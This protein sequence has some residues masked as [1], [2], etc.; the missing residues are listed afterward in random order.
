VGRTLIPTWHWA[1]FPPSE[2]GICSYKCLPIMTV[3]P[4]LNLGT[5]AQLPLQDKEDEDFLQL[6]SPGKKHLSR[7][8]KVLFRGL[9]QTRR[10]KHLECPSITRARFRALCVW[11]VLTE[12]ISW[13]QS[14]VPKCPRW[15]T[16]HISMGSEN[17]AGFCS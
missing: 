14:A 4:S 16:G 13:D 8:D 11:M 10:D 3:H 1:F 17:S 5:G 6:S 9:C 15:V 2:E 12:Q 7:Q